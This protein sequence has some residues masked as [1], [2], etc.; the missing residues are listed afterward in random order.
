[1]VSTSPK[2]HPEQP[3]PRP[4]ANLLRHHQGYR[5]TRESSTRKLLMTGCQRLVGQRYRVF[6]WYSP[7]A[8]GK[9]KYCLAC[10]NRVSGEPRKN[11]HM[12]WK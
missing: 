8:I 2:P 9:C 6:L 1:M 11:T 3:R 4:W 12:D 5:V 7:L 10:Y